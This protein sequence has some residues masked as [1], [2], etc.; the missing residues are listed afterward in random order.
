MFAGVELVLANGDKMLVSLILLTLVT[1]AHH[2]DVEAYHGSYRH[3]R[4]KLEIATPLLV[5]GALTF[6]HSVVETILSA[7][8][9]S[10][11]GSATS[12]RLHG[13]LPT[14]CSYDILAFGLTFPAVS[15]P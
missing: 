5:S 10:F 15:L 7:V 14:W 6:I 8:I 1:G 13:H 3:T 11:S 2:S 9:Q 4:R 12:R